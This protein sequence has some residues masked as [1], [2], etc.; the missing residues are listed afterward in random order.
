LIEACRIVE[1]QSRLYAEQATSSYEKALYLESILEDTKPK[2]PAKGWRPLIATPFRY[3]VPITPGYQARFRPPFFA[4]N[5]LYASRELRTTL[6]EHAYHFLRERIHLNGIRETGLR[7]AFTLFITSPR[8]TDLR[9]H[10]ALPKIMDRRDYAASHA[11]IQTH[12]DSKVILYPSCRDPRHGD[13]FAVLDIHC[14]ARHIG[15]QETLSFYFEPDS[16]SLV[17]MESGLR[18]SWQEIS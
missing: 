10:K 5:V 16:S 13:N 2:L 1:S 15:K 7:T 6:Y 3:P 11:F 4:K 18:I 8:V 9:K 12:P 17:W 14:L